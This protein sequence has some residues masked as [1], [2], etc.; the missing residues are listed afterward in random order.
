MVQTYL[1]PWKEAKYGKLKG[2]KQDDYFKVEFNEGKFYP[3]DEGYILMADVTKYKGVVRAFKP[4]VP[5]E[6]GVCAIPIYKTTYEIWEKK[7]KESK[8]TP[9]KC[10]PSLSE[11]NLA[12]HLNS[13]IDK[14]KTYQGAIAFLP[15]DQLSDLS[16]EEIMTNIE[17]NCQLV[18]T[19]S[20]GNLP[21]YVASNGTSKKSGGSYRISP[22]EKLTWLKKELVSAIKDAGYNQEM[23]LIDLTDQIVSES[24]DD[25]TLAIYVDFVKAIL[26][27]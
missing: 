7:D 5:L 19:E 18:E 11:R 3:T 8:A 14:D 16:A 9:V 20:T 23:S 24:E 21:E 12:S 27:A 15:D 13:V 17:R 6:P 1:D 22:S 26:T 25:N 4:E 10:Q 2:K